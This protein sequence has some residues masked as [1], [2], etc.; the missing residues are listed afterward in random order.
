MYKLNCDSVFHQNLTLQP[1]EAELQKKAKEEEAKLKRL[2]GLFD[3]CRFFLAREVPREAL[4]FVI[5]SFGGV[6]SWEESGAAGARYPESDN[7]I[8]HQIV[9]RP[10]LSHR[11]LSRWVKNKKFMLYLYCYNGTVL[12]MVA[13]SVRGSIL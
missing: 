6:V 13:F 10:T 3:G 11:Y 5:R 8:T 4:T 1:E 9:D 2:Q 12:Q 7:S